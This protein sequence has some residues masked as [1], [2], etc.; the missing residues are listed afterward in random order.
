MQSVAHYEMNLSNAYWN[1]TFVIYGDGNGVTFREFSGA[2]DVVA[3][4]YG[5]RRH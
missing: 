5:A 2:L 3:H 1:G 4:E